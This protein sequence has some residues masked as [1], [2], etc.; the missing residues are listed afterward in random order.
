[1][2]MLALMLSGFL[3]SP[4]LVNETLRTRMNEAVEQAIMLAQITHMHEFEGRRPDEATQALPL[5]GFEIATAEAGAPMLTWLVMKPKPSKPVRVVNLAGMGKWQSLQLVWWILTCPPEAVFAVTNSQLSS[6]AGVMALTTTG[7]FQAN[8]YDAMQLIVVSI[9]I[10]VLAMAAMLHYAVRRLVLSGLDD[11]FV[12]LY[13]SAVMKPQSDDGELSKDFFNSLE[14]FQDRMRLHIDEQAR[15]A[16]LGAGASFLA[17]D[18][19]NLL[20]TLHLN[21]EQLQQMTGEKERCIGKRRS[22]AIEQAM[23]LA[24]WA[25]L[26]TSHKRDSLDVGRQKL[27]P[28]VSD[29]LNFVRLHDPKQRVELIN[30]CSPQAEVV[31]EPTLLFSIIYNLVLNA[32]Q[33]MKGHDRRRRITIEALSDETACM[34]Y[35]SDTSPGLPNAGAG[36]LLMPHMSGFGRLT[37]QGWG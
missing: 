5:V 20:A 17:H 23:S 34:I 6:G 9:L 21:A 28:I 27:T 22:V 35:V 33:S 10:G 19:R 18:M 14:K 31:A 4:I 8:A 36:T 25:T 24:E 7:L 29:A 12:R 15:L 16:S 37:A 30:E 32:M 26:Y 2:A 11:L 3:L 1:M 13:G